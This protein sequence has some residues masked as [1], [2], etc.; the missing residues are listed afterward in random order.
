MP[1]PTAKPV[2]RQVR[3]PD[4]E[5]WL[6]DVARLRIAVFRAWPYLYDGDAA[7][8]RDYLAAYA[9]SVDSVFVLALD[10][11]RVVGASTALR[12]DEEP[13]DVKSALRAAGFEPRETLYC[14]ESV[15]DARYRGQGLGVR[16]FE[17]RERHARALGL[18][19]VAFCRVVRSEDHPMRPVGAVPLDDFWRHRG[20]TRRPDIRTEFSW[21]DL[22]ETAESAKP[23]EFWVK[24]LVP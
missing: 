19:H 5:P 20:Y 1:A 14:G 2:I 3:G 23:M 8:E 18:R 15:L 24:T 7:Y 6:V 9:R 11:D 16:F 4:I 12:L 22:G 13:E 17:E 21:R 10:G